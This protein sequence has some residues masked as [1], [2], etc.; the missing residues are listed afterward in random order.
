MVPA[1]TLHVTQ[2]EE[3]KTKTP[4]AVHIGQLKGKFRNK[5][6]LIRQ[7]TLI[8]ITTL[9]HAEYLAGLT[10]IQFMF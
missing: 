7:L 9:T 1:T 10:G 5:A 2:I 4:I 6:V 8:A 3:A